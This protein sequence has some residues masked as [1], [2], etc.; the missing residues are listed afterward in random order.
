MTSRRPILTTASRR[1][2]YSGADYVLS[3]LLK[4]ALKPLDCFVVR[5]PVYTARTL[6]ESDIKYTLL[7]FDDDPAGA[8]LERYARTLPHR[9][10]TPVIIVKNSESFDRLLDAIRRQLATGRAS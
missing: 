5:S 4:D 9:E 8:E 7:L 1:I 6:V 10:H 2:L 3:E